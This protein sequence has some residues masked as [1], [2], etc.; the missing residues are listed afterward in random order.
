MYIDMFSIKQH[1]HKK[2]TLLV[3]Y[4]HLT[5]SKGYSRFSTALLYS[6]RTMDL[7]IFSPPPQTQI[8]LRLPG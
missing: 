1:G 6:R 5:V 3:H 2:C 7:F 4:I 8:A